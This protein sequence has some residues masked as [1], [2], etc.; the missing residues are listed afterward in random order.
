M[1]DVKDNANF[2][3][4]RMYF[5]CQKD[6]CFK[7][8]LFGDKIIDHGGKI[9]ALFAEIYSFMVEVYGLSMTPDVIVKFSN[10]DRFKN[11]FWTVKHKLGQSTYS[12][13][14]FIEIGDWMGKG[15][16]LKI[17][18]SMIL[19]NNLYF[20]E[21]LINKLIEKQ[22]RLLKSLLETNRFQNG[23]KAIETDD[24]GYTLLEE[25]TMLL[26]SSDLFHQNNLIK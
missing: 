19:Y 12:D 13:P 10:S 14:D 23:K 17:T 15:L 1:S 24:W 9:V 11:W 8:E 6:I 5:R 25:R 20:D 4:L 21:S 26:Y 18:F 7:S 22:K 16:F 2:N 3:D